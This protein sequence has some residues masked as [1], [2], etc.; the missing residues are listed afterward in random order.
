VGQRG[1][2]CSGG[3]KLSSQKNQQ[4]EHANGD[5]KLSQRKAAF[6]RRSW[7]YGATESAGALTLLRQRKAAGAVL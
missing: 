7:D 2:G 1:N 4:H 6:V 5:Q 3:Q